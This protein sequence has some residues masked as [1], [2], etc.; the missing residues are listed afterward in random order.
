MEFLDLI[1]ELKYHI[2]CIVSNKKVIRK[3]TLEARA[4][5]IT[6]SILKL[7]SELVGDK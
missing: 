4:I 1:P 7:A 6:I 5:E 2:D 3:T